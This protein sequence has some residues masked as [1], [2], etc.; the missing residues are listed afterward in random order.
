MRYL[1]QC[2]S[3]QTVYQLSLM[4]LNITQGLVRCAHC[5]HI[6]DAYSC[7]IK[8]PDYRP[9]SITHYIN[10]MLIA[11]QQNAVGARLKYSAIHSDTENSLIQ[12]V[13][14]LMSQGVDGS[15]LNL[16]TYLNYLDTLSP[17]HSTKDDADFDP[18]MMAKKQKSTLITEK[19]QKKSV[20]YY[21]VWGIIHVLLISLL[22]YQIIFFHR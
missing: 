2:P 16:Y 3:C 1:S 13:N 12:H 8:D 7:F 6:F 19:K 17:I 11:H 22:L 18:I 10:D 21:L 14:Q 9:P 20:L 4:E 5:R 15:Q